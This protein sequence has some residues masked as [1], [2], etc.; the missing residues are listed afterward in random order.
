[1]TVLD[2]I[3]DLGIG[4]GLV[5][6]ELDKYLYFIAILISGGLGFSGLQTAEPELYI[7]SSSISCKLPNLPEVRVD[8]SQ[9]GGHSGVKGGCEERIRRG[10]SSPGPAADVA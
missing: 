6:S 2:W 10:H 1:M 8:L 4:L 5:L 7:P 9:D 3:G